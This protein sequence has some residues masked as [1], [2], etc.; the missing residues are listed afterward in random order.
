M[1]IRL[2]NPMSETPVKV[3][4]PPERLPSLHGKTVGLLD[5]SKAGG[6]LFL[7]RLETLLR[8]RFQVASFSVSRLSC[9]SGRCVIPDV[10]SPDKAADGEKGCGEF[11]LVPPQ[12]ARMESGDVHLVTYIC[13]AKRTG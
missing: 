6:S 3:S 9:P 5:I 12:V 8:E 11:D 13:A 2:I 7:D 4:P 1:A 10:C